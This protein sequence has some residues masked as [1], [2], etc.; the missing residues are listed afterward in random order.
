M[1]MGSGHFGASTLSYINLT[2]E[3]FCNFR[4]ICARRAAICMVTS[5]LS[6]EKIPLKATTLQSFNRGGT[7]WVSSEVKIVDDDKC[8]RGLLSLIF[9]TQNIVSTSERN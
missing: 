7:R 6:P 1:G 4:S 9:F 2:W 3:K 8:E 5:S